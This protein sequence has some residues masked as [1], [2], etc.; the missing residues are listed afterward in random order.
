L[1]SILKGVCEGLD[2]QLSFLTDKYYWYF[3]LPGV[4]FTKTS[5][6][7]R[8]RLCEKLAQPEHLTAEN[9]AHRFY[10]SGHG[11]PRWKRTVP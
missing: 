8:I 2:I 9:M 3:Y 11:M 10:P 1:G 5:E 7:D 4:E 6:P